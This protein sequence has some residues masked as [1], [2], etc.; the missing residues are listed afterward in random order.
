M[1]KI[2]ITLITLLTL[3]TNLFAQ[4]ME[5]TDTEGK[6]Y[7]VVG[8]NSELKIEGME[9]KVVFL[10]FFGLKCPACKDAMPHLINIQNKYKDKVQVMA[11]EVQKNDVAP[12][13]A[14]KKKHGINYTTF[15]NYDVGYIVRYIADKSGWNGAIPFLV[16]IDSKGQVRFT[17]A[18][19]IPEKTLAKYIEDFSK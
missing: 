1:K 2:I 11:I 12:I 8:T 13:N 5:M 18:G 7:S 6:R 10:E 4:N 3:S 16:A 19:V 9:G 15:S 17:Q 14:Y